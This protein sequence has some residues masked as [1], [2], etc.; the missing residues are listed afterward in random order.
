MGGGRLDFLGE[1]PYFIAGKLILTYF[2]T[3]HCILNVKTN[4][5]QCIKDYGPGARSVVNANDWLSMEVGL[6][7]LEKSHSLS[8][9]NKRVL[10]QFYSI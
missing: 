10:P 8:C 9:I 6:I 7:F 4:L 3:S 2:A 1:I 5:D